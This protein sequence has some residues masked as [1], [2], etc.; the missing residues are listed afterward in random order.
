MDFIDSFELREINHQFLMRQVVFVPAGT[1]HG[2][3]NRIGDL[4]VRPAFIPEFPDMFA[5]HFNKV[6]K[7]LT[8]PVEEHHE[9]EH[10][11]DQGRCHGNVEVIGRV[12]EYRSEQAVDI[13]G[14]QNRIHG[15]ES[16]GD[17]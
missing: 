13:A 14:I 2:R 5:V 15:H 7:P 4:L 11:D 17:Q 6:A 9:P 10:K 3:Q 1:A 12:G 16:D 8:V